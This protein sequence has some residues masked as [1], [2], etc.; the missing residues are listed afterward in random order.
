MYQYENQNT[1][2]IRQRRDY[3][4]N[5][6]Y[7]TLEMEHSK[8]HLKFDLPGQNKSVWIYI[9]HHIHNVQLMLMFTFCVPYVLTN[10]CFFCIILQTIWFVS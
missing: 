2:Q 3:I 7:F 9:V 5:E 6:G 4:E 1:C 8:C 10:P